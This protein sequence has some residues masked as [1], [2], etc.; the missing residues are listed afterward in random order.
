MESLYNLDSKTLAFKLAELALTKKADD[1]KILDLRKITTI[2]DFFVICTAHS[3]PQVKAVADAI[4]EGA[5]KDGETVWHKEGT[6]MKS[7]VLLDFVDVVVHVFLKDTRAFYSLEKLWGDAEITEVTDEEPKG[8]SVT[9]AAKPKTIKKPA[10]KK[11]SEKKP[12]AKKP[13]A[14]R[15]PAKR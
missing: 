11:T 14:K 7:W 10:A 3:E 12:A 2:A 1:I 6:N 15:K 4:L 8:R 9:K 13:A 5:K